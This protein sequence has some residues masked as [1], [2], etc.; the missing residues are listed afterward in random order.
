MLYLG[1][2]LDKWVS[3]LLPVLNKKMTWSSIPG[4]E[5]VARHRIGGFSEK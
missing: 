5:R 2:F 3:Y 4:K 1:K